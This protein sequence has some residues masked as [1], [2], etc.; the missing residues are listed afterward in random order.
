MKGDSEK[1]PGGR[2]QEELDEVDKE[3]LDFYNESEGLSDFIVDD[4]E[5]DFEVSVLDEPEPPPRSTRRL[6]QGRRPLTTK[7]SGSAKLEARI[8]SRKPS[9]ESDSS[10]DGFKETTCLPKKVASDIFGVAKSDGKSHVTESRR[11]IPRGLN[12]R[13]PS[14]SRDQ[15]SSAGIDDPFA[16]IRL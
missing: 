12:K 14:R 16:I 15:E 4:S 3:E 6:V 5:S 13:L 11:D 8:E 2:D 7:L 9:D 1:E 10:E